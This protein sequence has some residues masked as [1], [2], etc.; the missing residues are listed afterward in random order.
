MFNTKPEDTL[1]RTSV[2][3]SFP[4]QAFNFK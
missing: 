1:T 4:V 3:I 2:R